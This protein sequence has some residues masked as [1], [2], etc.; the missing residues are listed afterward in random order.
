MGVGPGPDLVVEVIVSHPPEDS[1]E[2][3][4]MF[5]VREVW[6]IED[7]ELMFLALG[8]N[9]QYEATA[10]SVCFPFLSAEEMAFWAFRNDIRN[11]IELRYQFRVWV[12]EALV[13]RLQAR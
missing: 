3:Y 7:G 6:L 12:S 13:P 2:C 1:L 8:E 10:T 4:R 9:G 11:E 5:G